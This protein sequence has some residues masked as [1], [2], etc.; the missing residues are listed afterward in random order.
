VAQATAVWQASHADRNKYL[1][2]VLTLVDGAN[3]AMVTLTSGYLTA[4]ARELGHARHQALS[5]NDYTVEKLRG[6]KAVEVYAR[7]YGALYGQLAAGAS[8]EEAHASAT[9]ALGKLAATDTHMAYT[10][11]ARD[12]MAGDSSVSAF[13][14]VPSGTCDFCEAAAEGLYRPSTRCPS[15]RTV[16]ATSS[17]CSAPPPWWRPA[18]PFTPAI[19]ALSRRATP[20]TWGPGSTRPGTSRLHRRSGVAAEGLSQWL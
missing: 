7:P 19:L 6:T 20:A 13:K 1:G 12:W 15:T 11:S 2:Q 17:P 16:S 4:K 14:R 9:D 3:R 5:L 10:A 18:W 8:E